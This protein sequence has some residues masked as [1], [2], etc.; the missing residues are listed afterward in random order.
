MYLGEFGSPHHRPG[1][2]DASAAITTLENR[3][4]PPGLQTL[5]QL[6]L[7]LTH[8]PSTFGSREASRSST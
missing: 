8:A 6:C 2:D 1:R 5:D 4:V 3:M 7:T